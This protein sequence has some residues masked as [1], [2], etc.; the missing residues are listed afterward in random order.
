MK[1]VVKSVQRD[2]PV[3]LTEIDITT[4]SDLEHRYRNE[5][6]VLLLDKTVVAKYRVSASQLLAKLTST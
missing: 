4:R 5:V 6:P 3:E 1:S 2:Y